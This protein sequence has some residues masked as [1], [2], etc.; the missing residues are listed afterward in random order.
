MVQLRA[1][2][3][4]SVGSLARIPVHDL[5]SFSI[6]SLGSTLRAR[7]ASRGFWGARV[8][9]GRVRRGNNFWI[10]EK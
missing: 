1:R 7:Y 5:K 8:G 4:T 2:T 6:T 10:V 3:L 9:E